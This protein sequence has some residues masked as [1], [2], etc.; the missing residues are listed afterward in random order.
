MYENC[1]YMTHAPPAKLES[2]SDGKSLFPLKRC[3]NK[4]RQQ[5]SFVYFLLL[6]QEWA[7]TKVEIRKLP[8]VKGN[9]YDVMHN[10][11]RE[12]NVFERT[13]NTEENSRAV[14]VFVSPLLIPS[15]TN[16]RV[17]SFATYTYSC[18][19]CPMGFFIVFRLKI[20]KQKLKKFQRRNVTAIRVCCK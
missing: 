7:L 4:I 12:C 8:V 6:F 14:C 1:R 20:K 19:I 18:R 9:F 5:P 15:V 2:W 11:Y 10:T 16:R 3:V 17:D 13:R